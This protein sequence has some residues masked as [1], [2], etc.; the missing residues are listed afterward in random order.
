MDGEVPE[1]GLVHAVTESNGGGSEGEEGREGGV[2]KD[3]VEDVR[4]GLEGDGL[5][6]EVVGEEVGVVQGREGNKKRHD[7]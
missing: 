3:G 6:A 4:M 1:Q 5:L 2:G 7:E